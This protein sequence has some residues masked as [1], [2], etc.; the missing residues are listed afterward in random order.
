M[1]ASR[2]FLLVAALLLAAWPTAAQIRFEVRETVP[3][4]QSPMIRLSGLT[5]GETIRL[6]GVRREWGG[7]SRDA[8]G[9]WARGE[10]ML[11]AWADFQADAEGRVDVD[12]ATPVAGSY[13]TADGLGLFW[14][15][16]R[17]GDPALAAVEDARLY[18]PADKPFGAVTVTVVR[19]G[20]P[21]GAKVIRP[22][23]PDLVFTPVSEPGLTGVFAAPTGAER[24]PVIIQLHGSE[25]G[26]REGARMRAAQFAALGYA[27]LAI[28]Y[29][30]WLD[31]DP[32]TAKAHIETPIET[33]E[34]ARDWLATRPEADVEHLAVHGA[35]KGAEFSLVGAVRYPW[36]DAVVACVP[37]DLVWEGYGREEWT[38]VGQSSWS[39]EGRPLPFVPLYP[40][41]DPAQGDRDNTGRY[42][43]S[44]RE[45][46][47]AGGAARIPVEQAGGRLLLIGSD[48]D[49]V[50]A[51][52]PMIRRLV[53]RAEAAGTAGRI[54]HVIYP[55]AGHGVC[56][57]GSFPA[58]LYSDQSPSPWVREITAE[59]EATRDS[60]A[61][62]LA[63]LAETI[64]PGSPS[65]TD[66]AASQ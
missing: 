28:N 42:D 52:G 22:A 44:L 13:R 61:R 32:N 2:L 62:T 43:R 27:V 3:D 20:R 49:E 15:G 11:D 1:I 38:S 45:L 55:K 59:G 51:S 18:N 64:G 14:S 9:Q 6:H 31:E 48:R 19:G 24:L 33:L 54:E 5:P 25:G 58:R 35:S 56:G 16:Y 36:I 47:D 8:S 40:S 50:W 30:S 23:T 26:S 65:H 41:I 37:S 34:R 53:A 46:G 57:T 10:V 12:S 7:W 63:F 66:Q 17:I 21:I 4:G 60:W 29:F 39:F